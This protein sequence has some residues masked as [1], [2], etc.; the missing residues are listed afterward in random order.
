MA[1]FY[2]ITDA[3]RIPNA[4]SVEIPAGAIDGYGEDDGATSDS[5]ESQNLAETV[6]VR[7]HSG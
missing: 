6:K 7:S 3:A 2:E 4:R 5:V 1:D